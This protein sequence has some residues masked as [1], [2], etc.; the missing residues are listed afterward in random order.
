MKPKISKGSFFRHSILLAMAIVLWGALITGITEF[1]YRHVPEFDYQ[2]VADNIIFYTVI[3]GLFFLEFWQA[4]GSDLT[5][6][7]GFKMYW[8]VKWLDTIFDLMVGIAT[9]YIIVRVL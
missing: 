3:I 5:K 8:K 2:S 6:K 9:T 7:G 1:A 4:S